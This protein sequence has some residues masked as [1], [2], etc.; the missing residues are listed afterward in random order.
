MS[1]QHKRRTL[2]DMGYVEEWG[3]LHDPSSRYPDAAVARRHYG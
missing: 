2:G 1:E 3:P